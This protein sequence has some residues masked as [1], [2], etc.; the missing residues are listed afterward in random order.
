M[1]DFLALRHNCKNHRVDAS[2]VDLN[3]NPVGMSG[4]FIMRLVPLGHDLT[5]NIQRVGG[6][7]KYERVAVPKYKAV[8]E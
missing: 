6:T 2:K 1:P 7:Y 3:Y 5:D 4:A 8:A